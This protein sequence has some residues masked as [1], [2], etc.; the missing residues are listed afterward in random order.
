MER[1]NEFFWSGGNRSPHTRAPYHIGCGRDL[2]CMLGNGRF[3]F[4]L[5]A[6][7]S[8]FTITGSG[9]VVK[10]IGNG[11]E[12]C[13]LFPFQDESKVCKMYQNGISYG[14][15]KLPWPG[16][17]CYLL[18]SQ[19]TTILT[20]DINSN[21]GRSR[22]TDHILIMFCAFWCFSVLWAKTKRTFCIFERFSQ[23]SELFSY[24]FVVS[25]GT[26]VVSDVKRATRSWTWRITKDTTK[27]PIVTREYHSRFCYNTDI[28]LSDVFGCNI[29]VQNFDFI[30]AWQRL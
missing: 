4:L 6:I 8:S 13:T 14:K 9:L 21:W 15:T 23:H 22:S 19:F 3:Y 30:Y 16:N 7:A 17:E 12:V 18:L 11:K 29:P 5:E 2:H 24:H 27:S 20:P 25:I 10:F 28:F 26:R 1:E